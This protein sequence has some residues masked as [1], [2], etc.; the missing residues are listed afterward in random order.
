MNKIVFNL[1]EQFTKYGIQKNVI[2]EEIKINKENMNFKSGFGMI[3]HFDTLTQYHP[4]IEN[5]S[6]NLCS[7]FALITAFSFMESNLLNKV[8]HEKNIL[9]SDINFSKNKLWNT[10]TFDELL[11]YSDLKKPNVMLNEAIDYTLLF[12]KLDKYCVIFLK[13]GRFF[14]VT[15]NN[16]LYSIRDCHESIQY[17]F[18]DLQDLINHLEQSYQFGIE[19][20]L[21]GYKIS[22]YNALEYLIVD[23]RFKLSQKLAGFDHMSNKDNNVIRNKESRSYLDDEDEDEIIFEY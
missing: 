13:N 23:N 3:T 18:V 17:N 4:S 20:D 21:D 16:S 6:G 12:P 7:L 14:V 10:M 1:D 9:L 2:K 5:R 15:Y 11:T 8:E 19:I 22:E